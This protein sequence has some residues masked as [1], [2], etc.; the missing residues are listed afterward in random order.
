MSE[1]TFLRHGND[2][3]V[4]PGAAFEYKELPVGTY[5][6]KLLPPMGPFVLSVAD[7][8]SAP[9]KL[10]GDIEE[11]ADLVI[12]TFLA[13]PGVVTGVMLIGDKGSGKTLLAKRIAEK[14]RNLHKMPALLLNEAFGGTAFLE[15]L[16]HIQQSCVLIIDEADK[17]Y[18]GASREEDAPVGRGILREPEPQRDNALLTLLDGAYSGHKLV[19]Y[20][21][22]EKKHSQY[23]DDRPGRIHYGWQ[24][25]GL[26]IEVIRQYGMDHLI[27]KQEHMG[28]F[29][30][31]MSLAKVRSFDVMRGLIWEMNKYGKSAGQALRN[32]TI[33]LNDT[34]TCEVVAAGIGE[35]SGRMWENMRVAY[36]PLTCSFYL[37][38]PLKTYQPLTDLEQLEL[39]AL[40][41]KLSTNMPN[42]SAVSGAVGDSDPEELEKVAAWK[43]D[44]ERYD[45]L[46][47]RR[48]GC[49]PGSIESFNFNKTHLVDENH[50]Q[51]VYQFEN[52]KVMVTL[53]RKDAEMAEKNYT[54]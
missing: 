10:Y 17:S 44:K 54:F 22:N 2:F 27:K 50:I 23:L 36:N 42:F 14:L 20:I 47:A 19:L 11:R 12:S 30:L 31:A 34:F 48:N 28:S 8:L 51:G 33:N 40:R 43:K 39:Q 41:T 35:L 3:H 13:R 49:E 21:C 6:I 15:F 4:A 25:S 9:G 5:S 29:M 37:Q 1:A 46:E 16:A 53:T 7:D 45:L 18:G 52:E 32:M 26:S 38:L 24:Y